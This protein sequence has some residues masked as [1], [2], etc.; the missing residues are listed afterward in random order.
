MFLHYCFLCGVA[1]EKIVNRN[2]KSIAKELEVVAQTNEKTSKK[3]RAYDIKKAFDRFT[4]IGRK[5]EELVDT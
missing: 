1:I 2:G 4:K 3:F 5:G